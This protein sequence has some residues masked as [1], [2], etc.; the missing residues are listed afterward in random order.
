MSIEIPIK[1]LTNQM[2]LVEPL[3]N[4]QLLMVEAQWWYGESAKGLPSRCS[5]LC[6]FFMQEVVAIKTRASY[7]VSSLC[8][9]CLLCGFFINV[10][11]R[12]IGRILGCFE[13]EMF[14]HF[15][16]ISTYLKCDISKCLGWRRINGPRW[17][18]EFFFFWKGGN[19]RRGIC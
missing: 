15:P 18:S 10:K 4:E 5:N 14:L 8:L 1:T 19:G 3:G 7:K 13:G 12:G 9:L 17:R 2:K 16:F 6:S 11:T